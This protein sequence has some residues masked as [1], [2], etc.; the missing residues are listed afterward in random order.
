M[1]QGPIGQA[2]SRLG[3]SL[4]LPS[5]HRH[6][7]DQKPDGRKAVTPSRFL[8]RA[9]HQGHPPRP[10]GRQLQPARAHLVQHQPR[11]H[12]RSDR[13]ASQGLL[14][15]PEGIRRTTGADHDEPIDRQPHGSRG[16]RIKIP[17]AVHHHEAGVSASNG[18]QRGSKGQRTGPASHPLGKHL[19]HRAARKPLARE[20]VVQGEPAGGN[21][22]RPPAA[23]REA[24]SFMAS[25]EPAKSHDCGMGGGGAKARRRWGKGRRD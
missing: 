11:G 17:V 13:T 8:E 4:A 25:Q 21:A 19:D 23:G 1:R 16:R 2:R 6:R 14:G 22:C 3:R 9:Q 7:L 24:A 15:R 12:H 5:R 10:L 18:V 20:P